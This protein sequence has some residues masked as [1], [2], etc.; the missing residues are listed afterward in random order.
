MLVHDYKVADPAQ[1]PW[2]VEVLVALRMR[3]QT[4]LVNITLVDV[5]HDVRR[6]DLSSEQALD[7]LIDLGNAVRQ[8]RTSPSP[9]RQRPSS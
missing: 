4:Q 1:V 8:L 9:R 6:F 7:L 2:P 5:V 3:D